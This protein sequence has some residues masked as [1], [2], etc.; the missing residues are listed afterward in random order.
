MSGQFM[1]SMASDGTYESIAGAGAEPPVVNSYDHWSSL[2]E[3]IVGEPS[4]LAY[5]DDVSFRLFFC[6][7]LDS[8]VS[9]GVREPWTVPT[10]TLAER[11]LAKEM[12]ED[13]AAFVDLLQEHDVRVRTPETRPDPRRVETPDWW[14]IDGH[15]VMPRD[16]LLVVGDEIIETA[17]L[18]RCRY[19]EADLYKDLLIE[20]FARGAK[21]TV[22][23][24]S[25]LRP[26]NFDYTYAL[27]NGYTGPVPANPRYE[28]MFD[29]AQTVRI[30]RDVLFNCSTE[31]HRL[32]MR[33]L[34]R[35]LGDN[36]RVHEINVVDN[37]VDTRVVPLRPGTLLL[38]HDVRLSQLP[39]FLH[40]WDIIR[41]SPPPDRL[42]RD[43]Y[44]DRPVL[45]A[46]SL[47]MNVLSLDEERVV[48]QEDETALMKD[49]AKAGF[50]PLP[51]RWRHGRIV[52]GGFHCMTLDVRRRSVLED[53]TS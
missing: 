48:V 28:I 14:T 11:Q 36:Y 4:F 35:H 31:N 41:Y 39:A 45:S 37:H 23:P 9:P 46:P 6:A 2:E 30:G 40:D 34:A 22:A 51:C 32:G 44:G 26:E 27:A 52:G 18:V 53:Y 10:G 25:R 29:G 7:D 24:H 21:W 13:L 8:P 20:Y 5:D 12:A 17:P 33:W 49:L 16:L 19:L 43:L 42:G 50:N 15:S 1:A 3:V 38:H 47:G